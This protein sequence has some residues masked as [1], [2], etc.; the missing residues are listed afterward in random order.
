MKEMDMLRW[1]HSMLI[2]IN[3]Y[4]HL[5]INSFNNNYYICNDK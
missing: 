3:T 2:M 5:I 4:H 1:N